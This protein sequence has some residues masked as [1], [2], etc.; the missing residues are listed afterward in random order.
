MMRHFPASLCRLAVLIALLFS[1]NIFAYICDKDEIGP[2]SVVIEKMPKITEFDTP[3]EVKATFK[4]TSD[5]SITVQLSA[6]SIEQVQANVSQRSI[7]V[8]ANGSAEVTLQIVCGPG[9]YSAHYPV[10]LFGDF[11]ING[12]KHQLHPVQVFE[13]DFGT[14]GTSRKIAG[15]TTAGAEVRTGDLVTD[16]LQLPLVV[17]PKQ[18]GL[19][20]VGS[21]AYRVTWRQFKDGDNAPFV[22]LNIGWQGGDE[23]SSTNFT[24]IRMTRGGVSREAFSV[25]PPYN[26]GAG[27]MFSEHLVALPE[28]KPIIFST[29]LAMRDLHPSEPPS[30]GVTFAVWVGDEKTGEKHTVSRTWEPFEVDLSRFAGQTIL[31]RL[32]SDPGPKR[33]TTCDSAFWGTPLLFAGERPKILT[34]EEKA[35][36]FAENLK[37]LDISSREKEVFQKY[38]TSHK[39]AD[40]RTDGT[41]PEIIEKYEL[42]KTVI[43]WLKN[44]MSVAI[45]TGNY[46]F[47][48]G[49]IGIGNAQNQVQYDGLQVEIEGQ[50]LGNELSALGYGAWKETHNP[51]YQSRQIQFTQQVVCGDKIYDLSFTLD[52]KDAALQ[53][54]VDCDDPLAITKINFGPATHHA[55]RVYFG[56]GYCITEPERFEVVNGGH[57]LS[58]SHV[59]FDFDNGISL[60]MATTFPPD[61]FIVDPDNKTYTLSVCN[62]TTMTLLPG[63]QNALECAIRYRPL[64]D[65]QAAPGVTKKAGRFVF[66]V[67]GGRYADHTKKM[68]QQIDYGVTDALFVNHNWQRW[69]YDNRLPDIWPPNPRWGTYDEL[70]ET[71]DLC[72]K[73]GILYGLHDNYIDI[74]PDADDFSYDHVSFEADGRPRKAWNNYGID[75]QSYQFRPDSFMPFLDR[76]F[77]MMMPEFPQTA[78]FVDVFASTNLSD[79]WDRNGNK[80]SRA[81]MLD[82]WCK[83]FDRIREHLGDNNPTISEGGS[84]F[85]IGHLDGAD[86]QFLMLSAEPGDFRINIRCKEWA[87]V[88]WF[89][90]V[91]HTRFSLHG[92]GYDSRYVA[93]RGNDL[94][95]YTSDDYMSTEVLTGHAMQVGYGN[96]GRDSIRKYWLLQPVIRN[97]ANAEIHTVMYRGGRSGIGP[98]SMM[99]FWDTPNSN[100]Y[101]RVHVNQSEQRE[102]FH[103]GM[104]S[105][106]PFIPQYGYTVSGYDASDRNYRSAIIGLPFMRKDG[107]YGSQI[108][109]LSDAIVGDERWVYFNPRQVGTNALPVM[110][111]AKSFEKVG[112]NQ[113]NL[114][115]DWN[116]FRSLKDQGD[117][118]N[119]AWFLHLEPPRMNWHEKLELAVLGGGMPETPVSEWESNQSQNFSTITFP[120]ELGSGTYNVLIGLWDADGNRQ[121]AKLL[122]PSPDN[123]RILLGKIKV[124]KRNGRV[125][126]LEF[127]PENEDAPE[128]F[129]RLLSAEQDALDNFVAPGQLKSEQQHSIPLRANGGVQ[130]RYPKDALNRENFEMTLMPLPEEP[131]TTVVLDID[132]TSNSL[133]P[134]VKNLK[135]DSIIA[136]DRDG[137]KLRDVEYK[138]ADDELR[139]DTQAGEFAYKIVVRK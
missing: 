131:A 116:V 6:K 60:L 48:D 76:N 31:L 42:P 120:D 44:D 65:K 16:A 105:W 18:G 26:G 63:N 136:I 54:G 57:N 71:L 79:F 21:D 80:H 66:D 9:T 41:K 127:V 115:V 126:K 81:E 8:S 45:T 132:G 3:Q 130:L 102:A 129:E 23:Q 73:H 10:H 70:R 62:A 17:V 108:V 12:Q 93:N 52:P 123:S 138:I 28:T 4:N 5:Q 87:R 24:K 1:T 38:R 37:A 124:E 86:C 33:D 59:G 107:T 84:D 85:L 11:E 56:H 96:I 90:A 134:N 27:T 69:G 50:P 7:S 117:V 25:H 72:R 14:L 92:V 67:W 100:V 139:F 95:G 39:Y 88:P 55:N 64:Y 135:C 104:E 106:S 20:L 109:E 122:G 15:N 89:D 34:P 91:N 99:F 103:P 98:D 30:D 35:A 111:V 58:T 82:N 19:S 36:M 110:P 2:L 97:L 77:K 47:L 137:K 128:L 94:H 61:R 119:L 74:Y 78:N 40:L 113:F 32:Q 49:V 101:T 75:A 133:V 114:N 125:T 118:K 51:H 112:D 46:G 29:Y 22:P 43:Y 13:T 68:Q 53:F 121:R 83:S